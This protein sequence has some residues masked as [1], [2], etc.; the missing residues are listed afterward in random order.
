MGVCIRLYRRPS[1]LGAYSTA[2]MQLNKQVWVTHERLRVTL[3]ALTCVLRHTR[4]CKCINCA[5]CVSE[6]TC[7]SAS[8]IASTSKTASASKTASVSSIASASKITGASKSRE[9]ES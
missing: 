1:L 3:R 4:E 5:A 2:Q 9:Q 6:I 8:K 7:V